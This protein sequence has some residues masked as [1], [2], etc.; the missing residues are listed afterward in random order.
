MFCILLIFNSFDKLNPE[1]NW[2]KRKKEK[3]VHVHKSFTWA[4]LAMFMRNNQKW[5]FQREDE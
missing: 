4:P 1:L 5:V 2:K 3:N